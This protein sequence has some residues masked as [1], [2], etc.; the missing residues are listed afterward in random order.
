MGARLRKRAHDLERDDRR[1]LGRSGDGDDLEI[2]AAEGS[3]V[4]DARGR[5]FI[6]FLMGWCVG[7][8]GWNHPAIVERLRQFEGPAYVMPAARYAPWVELARR[9]AAVTPGGLERCWRAVGGTEAVE[10]ALQLAMAYTGRRKLVS[11]EGAYH[12][13]SIGAASLGEEGRRLTEIP[14]CRQ[15]APPLDADAL[16][17]LE[18]LLAHRDVAAFIME[19]IVL[20]LGVEI[21]AYELVRGAAELCARYGTLLIADEVATGFGRTGA[22]FAC[23]HYGIEPDI[24]TLAKGITSGHAPLGAVITTAQIADGVRGKLRFY[25]TYAWH[26]LAVEAALGVLELFEREGDALLAN[27]AARSRQ[28]ASRLSAMAWPG[29][30]S[31]PVELRIKGLAIAVR[32][33]DEAPRIAKRCRAGGLLIGNE[34]DL[35]VMFPALTVDEATVDAALEIL[36]GALAA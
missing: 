34:G 16:G 28:L 5:T 23:E 12:G 19:P 13:N 3:R 32:V 29:A 36:E 26:P 2:A 11:I 10:L 6:D 25:S 17:R 31:H 4:T 35:L 21:P 18:A 15:L 22:M 20:N 27:V 7:N 9:L 8:L 30:R 33:G 14:G 24:M 1:Y